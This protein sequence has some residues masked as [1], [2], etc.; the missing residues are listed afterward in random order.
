MRIVSGNFR[1]RVIATPNNSVTRPTTD[2]ARESLFNIIA[3]APW[4]RPL[5][6]ARILDLFAGSGA[7]GFEA[8]SRGA[9]F[10]LFVDTSAQ[11]RGAI[12]TNIEAMKISACTRID[13][14]DCSRLGL[15]PAYLEAAFT[16]AFLDP[17]YNKS[18]VTPTLKALIAGQWLSPKAQLI[19]ETDKNEAFNLPNQLKYL[20]E[21]TI[22]RSC[23]SFLGVTDNCIA[24]YG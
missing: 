7:M 12:R 13:K 9:E 19:I 6:G 18:L 1:G 24:E 20:D 17:P 5:A 10:C 22:G 11:A 21:R 15:K 8:L 2:K 3:H 23:Y 14:R 16:L 4:A